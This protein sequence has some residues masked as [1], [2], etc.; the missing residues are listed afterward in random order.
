MQ[1]P[2]GAALQRTEQVAETVRK[3]LAAEN[4]VQSVVTVSGLNFLTG[5]N[6][7]NAAAAFAILKP[8]EE[9]GAGLSAS[10][11]IAAVRPKLLAMPEAI[12]LSFDPP[13]I[14]RISTTGGL[15]FEDADPPSH[16]PRSSPH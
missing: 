7:S 15:P 5:A 13:S 10:H 11:I 1:L 3:V 4:G 12:S 14:P 6:Q 2:D 9:R 16:R 8:W